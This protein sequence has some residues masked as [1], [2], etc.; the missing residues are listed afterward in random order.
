[1]AE[2]S[3]QG[4]LSTTGTVLATGTPVI[5]TFLSYVSTMRFNNPSAYTL[6]LYKYEALTATT[7]LIYNLN[8][9]AGDT[10]TDTLRYAL[11]EGDQIKAY[12]NITGTTYYANGI[13]Y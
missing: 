8:L 10:V 9:A 4:V 12:S 3:I 13:L 1:M 2:F 6:Q 11:N 7:T 5:G